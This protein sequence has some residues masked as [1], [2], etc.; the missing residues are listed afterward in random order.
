[1]RWTLGI[2]LTAAAC[3]ETAPEIIDERPA[4]GIV[5]TAVEA[6]Q[7][8]PIDIGLDGAEVDWPERN[9]PVL[10]GRP[11]LIRAHWAVG[12][13]WEARPILARLLLE[14]ADGE[15]SML[16]ARLEV[17]GDSDPESLDGAFSWSLEP[18]VL[19][20]HTRYRIEL[21]EADPG[22]E[23]GVETPPSTPVEGTAMV[24]VESSAQH[25]E[26]VLVPIER[27][28]PDCVA[29][30]DVGAQR[31]EGLRER[32]QMQLPVQTLELTVRDPVVWT[33][34]L[35]ELDPIID[36][37]G[38]LRDQDGAATQVH[39]YALL[40]N[41][42]KIGGAIGQA[43]SIPVV[44]VPSQPWTRVGVGLSLED[45]DETAH[46]MMHELGHALGR[47]HVACTGTE[48]KPD[49]SYPYRDG[50]IGRFGWG[51]L[52][53]ELR[54]PAER[55]DYMGYCFDDWVSDFGWAHTFLFIREMTGWGEGK[56]AEAEPLREL[57]VGSIDPDGTA[58][59]RRTRGGLAD[60]SAATRTT[61]EWL[62]DS[63]TLDTGVAE[64]SRRPD[65]DAI[66][67]ATPWPS[68]PATHLRLVHGDG[69]RGPTL[70][71]SHLR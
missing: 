12:N 67:L 69:T 43:H 58:R 9:G 11:T 48:N 19:E 5:L 42:G 2:V 71:V 45:F 41:C 24:G 39:Y 35:E 52:D 64:I 66:N 25:F 8:V 16:E 60:A 22:P 27:E 34:P 53:G 47:R 56:A 54:S 68:F 55:A 31:V 62:A 4:A 70:A 7:G 30:P 63:R 32:L 15:E 57:L 6:N 44:P 13:D 61:V 50:S 49:E 38:E 14:R 51:T 37:L 21:F 46:T 36:F 20:A 33:E 26:V 23:N 17:V 40:G 1:M 28:A 65:S 59:L 10:S 29:T 18:D 3:A